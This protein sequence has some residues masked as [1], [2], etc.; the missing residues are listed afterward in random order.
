MTDTG[1]GISPEDAVHV[2]ERFWQQGGKDRRGLGLGLY[3]CK[4]IVEA[5]GGSIRL[6]SKVGVGSRFDFTVPAHL[7]W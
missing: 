2:F 4:A 6:S 3:I 1:N 7:S 5:H